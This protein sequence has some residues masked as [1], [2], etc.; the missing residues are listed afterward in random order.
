MEILAARRATG[1]GR[2]VIGL[3]SAGRGTVE[4]PARKGF[5]H[6]VI[7]RMVAHSLEGTVMLDFAP[8]GFGWSVSFPTA[9]LVNGTKELGCVHGL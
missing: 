9:H 5:G 6:D 8:E 2:P 4:P 3:G 1:T 7:E